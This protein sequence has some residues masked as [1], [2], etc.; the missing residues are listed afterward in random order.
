M[1]GW[2]T[3]LKGMAGFIRSLVP[4]QGGPGAGDI[5]AGKGMTGENQSQS[6]TQADMALGTRTN[7]HTL[8]P[9]SSCRLGLLRA[10]YFLGSLRGAIY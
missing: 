6:T 8:E 2:T 7:R 3:L 9:S 10:R 1:T 5:E 4:E